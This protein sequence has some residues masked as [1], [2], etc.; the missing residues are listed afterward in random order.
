MAQ[1]YSFDALIDFLGYLGKKGLMNRNTVVSRK[2]SCNKVLSVLDPE[3]LADLRNL[4]LDVV[5]QRFAN[6]QGGEYAPKSL[7]VYKSRVNSS[8]DDFFRYKE[9][10]ANFSV[11]A[12]PRKRTATRIE[13]EVEMPRPSD[14]P[15]RVDTDISSRRGPTI[16]VPIALSSDCIV[17]INGLPVDVSH[18]EAKKIA[19]VIM[20]MAPEAE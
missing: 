2:A 14:R 3:E 11:S 8:L 6:L 5:A 15:P 18:S 9:N 4:D 13:S 7:R 12:T 16:N 19:N 1:D 20:A 10:P 17:Q